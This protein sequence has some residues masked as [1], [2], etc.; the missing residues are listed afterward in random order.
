MAPLTPPRHRVIIPRSRQTT[1][2]Q[3]VSRGLQVASDTSGEHLG[4]SIIPGLPQ[5]GQVSGLDS[6]CCLIGR[7]PLEPQYLLSSRPP[8]RPITRSIR[9]KG[10]LLA[11]MTTSS[12]EMGRLVLDICS[13]VY[14]AD[15]ELITEDGGHGDVCVQGGSPGVDGRP[16]EHL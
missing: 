10:E 6:K 2:Q 1:Q 7:F 15:T 16:Q 12:G 8:W 11:W 4:T 14:P 3:K 5:S 9:S 13:F